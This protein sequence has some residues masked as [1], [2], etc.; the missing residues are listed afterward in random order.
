MIYIFIYCADVRKWGE[1][2]DP[3]GIIREDFDAYVDFLKDTLNKKFD[4][5]NAEISAL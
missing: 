5:V 1:H 4:V 2:A 3:S